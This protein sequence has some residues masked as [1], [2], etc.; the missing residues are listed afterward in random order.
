MSFEDFRVDDIVV[1][2]DIPY[3]NFDTDD[4]HKELAESLLNK[5]GRV[6]YSAADEVDVEFQD[7]DDIW[8]I[9]LEFVKVIYRRK[10]GI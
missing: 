2:V 1:V 7:T 9:S 5:V 10:N 4:H 6:V 3:K 8:L